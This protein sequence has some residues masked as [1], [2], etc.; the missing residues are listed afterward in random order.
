MTS[1]PGKGGG[2]RGAGKGDS[3]S[4]D[5]TD[6]LG[7][8][9]GGGGNVSV[10]GKGGDGVVIVRITDANEV[11]VDVP[12]IH[13][14]TYTGDNISIHL[15]SAYEYVSGKTNETAVGNYSCFVKPATNFEWKDN[16]GS[17]AR[18]VT[19]KIV[20]LKL[21]MPTVATDL[22]YGGTNQVG[23]AIGADSAKYCE[24][25]SGS[26]TNATNAGVYNYKISIKSEHV[27]NVVWADDSTEVSGSWTIAQIVVTRPMP[28][29]GLIYDGNEKQGF[30][31]LDYARYK[32]TA[33]WR[34]TSFYVRASWQRRCGK[35]R[36][37]HQSSIG[38]SV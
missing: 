11:K 25:S 19:W 7:G 2:G 24:L 35:L 1:N 34:L 6:G 31:S 33:G 21:D 23:V 9:G 28:N 18:E 32:L 13:D 14:L 12:V 8:G 30:S 37:G 29:T 10:G 20:Q 22:V 5:G 38:R 36:L 27:G 26:A 4:G 3:K 16:G 15:V 17:E